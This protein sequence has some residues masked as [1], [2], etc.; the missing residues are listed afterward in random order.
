MEIYLGIITGWG[1]TEISQI[2]DDIKHNL[3]SVSFSEDNICY[4]TDIHFYDK[5]LITLIIQKYIEIGKG[6]SQILSLIKQLTWHVKYVQ[7]KNIFDIAIKMSLIDELVPTCTRL[8]K[9]WVYELKKTLERKV[10]TFRTLVY[11]SK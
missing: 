3:V 10:L 4:L 5:I 7:D 1:I 6:S 9:M 11:I 8:Q 2:T